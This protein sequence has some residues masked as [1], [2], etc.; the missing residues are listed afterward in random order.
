MPPIRY[1]FLDDG[2]VINDNSL[3]A[4]Q[5]RRLVGEFF[6]PRFV[7]YPKRFTGYYERIFRHAGV[8][9][10]E[11]L[12]VDD[13]TEALFWAREAG[14]QTALIS[15]EKHDPLAD[16][17]AH[18]LSDLTEFLIRQAAAQPRITAKNCSSSSRV[19]A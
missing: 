2:G 18:S 11:C 17:E 10:A 1:V 8:D 4:P 13:T 3:R 5:W 16:Y 12:V 14:A 6:V 19:A 9:P 15:F 7:N